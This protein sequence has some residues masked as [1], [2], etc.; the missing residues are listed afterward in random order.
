MGAQLKRKKPSREYIRSMGSMTDILEGLSV[1]NLTEADETKESEDERVPDGNRAPVEKPKVVSWKESPTN[2]ANEQKRPTPMPR[3]APR[4]KPAV[5]KS[6]T[7]STGMP[8]AGRR[9]QAAPRHKREHSGTQNHESEIKASPSHQ[10]IPERP[11]RPGKSEADMTPS[12]E[13]TH[14]SRD[15]PVINNR[16]RPSPRH[17][18][19]LSGTQTQ[20]KMSPNHEP[21]H[22]HNHE[23]ESKQSPPHQ[24]VPDRPPK[25]GKIEE[26]F[27][28]SKRMVEREPMTTSPKQSKSQPLLTKHSP[29][30]QPKPVKEEPEDRGYMV[31]PPNHPRDIPPPR[32]VQKHIRQ[33]SKDADGEIRAPEHQ[34]SVAELMG[35][36]PS[37]LSVKEKALLA[38]K[39]LEKQKEHPPPSVPW[40][41]YKPMGEQDQGTANFNFENSAVRNR[42][43][44]FDELDSS[45]K[46]MKK[47]LPGAVNIFGSPM[48]LRSATVATDEPDVRRESIEYSGEHDR[49]LELPME[50]IPRDDTDAPHPEVKVPPKRP[51]SSTAKEAIG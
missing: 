1:E 10:K 43:R 24:R 11:P 20:E 5:P 29:V 9:P 26:E 39:M 36:D 17:K 3:A 22:S 8:E 48:R 49:Y 51:S 23:P 40:K 14:E 31:E 12:H 30:L 44:S 32:L 19:E 46:R 37:E 41:P 21:S 7:S 13:H 42:A 15:S 18:R 45:P 25:P 28:S 6:E 34:N 4:H 2:E 35:K 50:P 47:I 27:A 38:Q 33:V 16:S